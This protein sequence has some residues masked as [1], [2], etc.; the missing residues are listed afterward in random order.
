M[1][2]TRSELLFDAEHGS[3]DA[4][5][6]LYLVYTRYDY[7]EAVDNN[8]Y[9]WYQTGDDIALEEIIDDLLAIYEDKENENYLCTEESANC[10]M[11]Y[12]G[13]DYNKYSLY[14]MAMDVRRKYAEYKR[15]DSEEE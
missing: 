11:C 8:A 12:L 3:M 7:D 15:K 6:D 4:L 1:T 13:E 2:Y 5:K 9:A 10:V 14:D